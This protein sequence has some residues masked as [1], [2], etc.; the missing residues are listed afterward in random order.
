MLVLL[1]SVCNVTVFTTSWRLPLAMAQMQWRKWGPTCEWPILKH[2][3]TTYLWIKAANVLANICNRI[4]S[5][6]GIAY[7]R[8]H[9]YTKCNVYW[10]AKIGDHILVWMKVKVIATLQGASRFENWLASDFRIQTPFKLFLNYLLKI[11]LNYKN[12]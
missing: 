10:F 7:T 12:S 11:Y 2:F 9:M 8:I 3:W 5:T 4:Y 1:V 6:C